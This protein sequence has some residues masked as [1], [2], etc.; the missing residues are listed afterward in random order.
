MT[1]KRITVG[2]H[3]ILWQAVPDENVGSP[4]DDIAPREEIGSDSMELAGIMELRD[5]Y[6]V[7]APADDYV[8]LATLRNLRGYLGPQMK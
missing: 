3:R 4:E 5:R 1:R 8:R 2:I 7:I 6:S